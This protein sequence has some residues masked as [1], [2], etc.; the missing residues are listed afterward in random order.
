MPVQSSWNI[1]YECD[2]QILKLHKL[3]YFK[4]QNNDS[5][6][7]KN[8]DVMSS[9]D[10]PEGSLCTSSIYSVRTSQRPGRTSQ[11]LLSVSTSQGSVCNSQKSTLLWYQLILTSH[12][13][14][15]PCKIK[16]Q[17]ALLTFLVCTSEISTALFWRTTLCTSRIITEPFSDISRTSRDLTINLKPEINFVG[18]FSGWTKSIFWGKF[19]RQLSLL[20]TSILPLNRGRQNVVWIMLSARRFL[21]LKR[22]ETIQWEKKVTAKSGDWVW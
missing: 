21:A 11:I 18:M 2:V 10:G 1:D 13:L 19:G 8:C 17:C 20:T 7:R 3:K 14:L 5:T 12:L 4:G 16:Y 22:I 6:L 15:S 9:Y